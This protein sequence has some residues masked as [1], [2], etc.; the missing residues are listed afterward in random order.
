MQRIIYKLNQ[1]YLR[2]N[3]SA[4]TNF[5]IFDKNY[6]AELFGARKFP[7]G[8]YVIDYMDEI[9]EYQ[10][11]FMEVVAEVRS[12]N[13]FTFPVLTY[14]LLFQN[15]KFAD[16]KFARWCSDH[17]TVWNDSNFFI[18]PDVT[19]LSSCCRLINDFS[20]LDSFINSI[21]GTSLKIGSVK[22]NTINLMR[23]AHEANNKKDYLEILRTKVHLCIKTLD[24]I[25][26]IIIRNV[27]KGLLPNYTKGLVDIKNQYNTIGINAMYE[28][29]R[30]FGLI[31][32]DSFGQLSYSQEGLDFAG[33]IMDLINEV[34][35]SYEF[36]YSIN[37]EAVPKSVGTWREI[38]WRNFQ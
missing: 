22:V 29:I 15:G 36:D 17:N 21:G 28:V 6:L 24:V 16:E 31:E 35:D 7:N 30:H 5:S 20:K 2:I 12:Q 23:I 26:G 18:G 38:S 25:R 10:K 33:E 11:T 9:M 1:P 32:E 27:E 19:S 13:M 4:F 14:S 37:V 34:K 3:Q 8:E